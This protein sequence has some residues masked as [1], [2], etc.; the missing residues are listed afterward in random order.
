L[1]LSLVFNY[2][3][4]VG[5]LSPASTKDLHISRAEEIL[6]K[7]AGWKSL[8][9]TT[10]FATI[11]AAATSSSSPS[12]PPSDSEKQKQ[13]AARLAF[14]LF[15]NRISG[16]IGAYYVAL[17][18]R[19]DALVFAGGI[20]EKSAALRAAVVDEVG[21]LGFRIDEGAN[22]KEAEDGVV[23]WDVTGAQGEG[24]TPRVLVCRTD[25]QFEMA[26]ACVEG[27]EFWS[28]GESSRTVCN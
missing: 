6:N 18:G 9:G 5:K 12:S 21:C 22:G 3:A 27:D 2:A 25:E 20:G 11:A 17:H 15:T 13:K 4:N 7:Q 16:F 14:N 26:R 1:F 10:N 19:V 8:T 24:G 28:G 23:V